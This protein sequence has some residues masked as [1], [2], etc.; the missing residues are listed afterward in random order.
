MMDRAAFVSA[1][2]REYGQASAERMADLKFGP[3]AIIAT[4][5]LAR[6]TPKT[7][8]TRHPMN[9]TEQRRAI[10]LDALQRAGEIRSWAFEDVTLRL[11]HRMRLTPDFFIEHTDHSI[12]FEEI[13][14][15]FIREDAWLKCKMAARLYPMF[16]WTLRQWKDGR[17]H[18][19]EIP[20]HVPQLPERYRLTLTPVG[21]VQETLS[22]QP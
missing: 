2:T 13:K 20:Q 19:S 22:T 9:R 12:E 18:V 5:S 6:R 14:G 1:A 8:K 21:A 11:A 16:R 7:P 4:P 3:A 15:G 10:E 17:W